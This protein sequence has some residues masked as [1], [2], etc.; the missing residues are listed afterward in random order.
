MID[1]NDPMLRLEDMWRR[2]GFMQ[3]SHEFWLL[4]NLITERLVHDRVSRSEHLEQ[5]RNDLGVDIDPVLSEFD[6]NN[7]R[8]VNELIVSFE[9]T[10]IM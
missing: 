2:I 7:M 8:Q 10:R 1:C 6:Q 3:H 4:A 9:N 5:G